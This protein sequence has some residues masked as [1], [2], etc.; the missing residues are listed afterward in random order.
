MNKKGEIIKK[1]RK[2]NNMTQIQLA[3][4]I[5]ISSNHLSEIERGKKGVSD[6]T[7]KKLNLLFNFSEVE[8][9]ILLNKKNKPI[10]HSK[11]KRL[12]EKEK[13]LQETYDFMRQQ[14]FVPS[15]VAKISRNLIELN[16]SMEHY[17]SEIEILL[18][19]R[20]NELISKIE[21]PLKVTLKRLKEKEKRIERLL[22]A[23]EIDIIE[24]E[25]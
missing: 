19:E 21:R 8:M 22:M 12:E 13:E 2:M 15:M 20:N 10:L 9:E 17:L 7:V 6:K 24:E 23:E 1:Y 18:D 11:Y 5:G 3:S 4:T 16:K 25:K 14:Y